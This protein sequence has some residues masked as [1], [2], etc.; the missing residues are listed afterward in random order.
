MQVRAYLRA[1]AHEPPSAFENDHPGYVIEPT[2]CNV[3]ESM[4]NTK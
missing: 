4:S 3:I 1:H 2:T